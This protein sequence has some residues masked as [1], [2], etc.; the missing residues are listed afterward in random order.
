MLFTIRRTNGYDVLSKYDF[1]GFYT[2]KFKTDIHLK[3]VDTIIIP[4]L[5][6]LLLLLAKV[7]HELIISMDEDTG[8]YTIEIYDDWRE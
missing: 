7:N 5:E 2:Q 4:T 3:T 1:T 6:D 8:L